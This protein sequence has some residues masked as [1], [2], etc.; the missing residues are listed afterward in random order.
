MLKMILDHRN[1]HLN[2]VAYILGSGPSIEKFNKVVDSYPGLYIGINQVYFLPEIKDKLNYLFTEEYSPELE[3]L[4]RTTIFHSDDFS[5]KKSNSFRYRDSLIQLFKEC[6]A[7]FTE[8]PA[9]CRGLFDEVSSS[10]FHALFFAL[11]AGCKKVYLV[12]CDCSNEG[13]FYGRPNSSNYACLIQG[14]KIIKESVKI[15][16]PEVEII[17]I[18]PVNLNI[19]PKICTHSEPGINFQI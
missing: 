1:K 18:N 16:F 5:V 3:N 13:V 19:F 7:P 10:A 8:T 6:E 17:S 11:Y 14:W 2:R 9:S 15:N 12:G 4:T